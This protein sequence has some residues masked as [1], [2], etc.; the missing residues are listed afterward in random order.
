[1][2]LIKCDLKYGIIIHQGLAGMVWVTHVSHYP[3]EFKFESDKDAYLFSK[4]SHA[5][6]V[7]DAMCM[8]GYSA[9]VVEVPDYFDKVSNSNWQETYEILKEAKQNKQKEEVCN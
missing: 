1:M 6:D 3:K 8:N 4:R 5:Q 7:A 2:R 9:F